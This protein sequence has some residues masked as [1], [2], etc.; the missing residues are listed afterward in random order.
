MGLCTKVVAV[1]RDLKRRERRI[2]QA[3]SRG[4]PDAVLRCRCKVILALVQ[5][6]SP[7][8]I[9]KGGLCSASQVY[10]VAARFLDAGPA[11]L[12]DQREDN[13]QNKVTESYQWE[14]LTVLGGSPRD[15]GYLRPTWTQELLVR[16]LT[17]RTGMTVSVATMSRLLK[18]LGVRL[19]RPKPTVGC[20]WPKSRRM[21]RL[22]WIRRLIRSLGPDEVAVYEDKVDI[23]LNPKIGPDWMLRGQQ[24][25][26]RTPGQNQKRY[27]AGALD[28]RTGKLT[29]IEG[30]RKNSTLF[31]LLI[32]R[33]VTVSYRKARRIHIIL[34]NF[35]IH[36]SRQVQLALAAWEGKVQ[37]H[38]LPPYC[39]DHNR[40]ERI[41]K[42]LHDNVTR[43]HCCKDMEELMADV[44]S[45]L[46]CRR[47]RGKHCYPKRKSA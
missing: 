36:D 13:G 14:V 16:V 26:V 46:R 20:P 3:W 35:K 29:W 12:A 30:E 9:A 22:A 18:R 19:G 43:N 17:A 5:G 45:Y 37:L 2:L 33:L 24:K 6:K 34:D 11:G 25:E 47:R 10:R 38:F 41:W 31:L 21:R 8:T 15:Y 27:L 4:S 23:H 32:H 7:T 39:P 1:W 28:A 44:D 40:I 42:D